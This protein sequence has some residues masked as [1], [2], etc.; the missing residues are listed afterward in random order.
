[1]KKILYSFFTIGFF[2]IFSLPVA[3]K[4]KY[5]NYKNYGEI[6]DNQL[7]V[8]FK[9]SSERKAQKK[10][11]AARSSSIQKTENLTDGSALFEYTDKTIF[12]TEFENLKNNPDVEIVQ[13]N[14]IYRAMFTSP[15]DPDYSL[16]T[17][18][19]GRQWG[20]AK[21]NIEKAWGINTGQNS[22]I[23]VA[24]LDTGVDTDHPDLK[25]R[26]YKNTAEIPGNNIDD[27]NNGYVDDYY[28]FNFM[29]AT[30]TETNLWKSDTGF[31]QMIDID[32]HGTWCSLIIG[33]ENNNL[34]NGCG[35]YQ[36]G[37]VL[38]VRILGD[39][40]DNN[41]YLIG[42]TSTVV[43]GIYYAVL[44]NAMMFFKNKL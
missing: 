11:A 4:I 15:N 24:V 8:K 6:V 36:G 38:P 16:D 19:T 26:L 32:G 29:G 42:T 41:R 7:L 25:N 2:I 12:E 10:Y 18:T 13:P 20:L 23:I 9:D 40:I 33:A 3:A 44:M 39:D 17:T 30:K 35:I 14:Y 31:A 43:E 21:I 27:D 5:S 22:N 34:T 28:G 37:K 1:M